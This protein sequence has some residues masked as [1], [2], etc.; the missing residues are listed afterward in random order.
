[1]KM[2]RCGWCGGSVKATKQ[3]L[4]C[5]WCGRV[6]AREQKGLGEWVEPEGDENGNY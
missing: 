4:C 2:N 3:G 1:M 5:P 6:V